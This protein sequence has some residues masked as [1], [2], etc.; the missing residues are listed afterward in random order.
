MILSRQS[1]ARQEPRPTFD[2]PRARAARQKRTRASYRL[3]Y[4]P[5]SLNQYFLAIRYIQCFSGI[6]SPVRF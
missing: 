2:G 4:A 3:L 5:K 6:S 1:A